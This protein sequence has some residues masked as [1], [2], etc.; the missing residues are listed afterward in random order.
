MNFSNILFAAVPVF[1]IVGVGYG[2]RVFSIV[3]DDSERSIMRLILNVLYPCFILSKV[4]GNESLEHVN[5]VVAAIAAG[6]GLTVL[7]LLI[8]KCIGHGIKLDPAD[9]VN[10]FCVATAIQNYGF[11]PIP[12]IEALFG[13]SANE[14]LGVLFVHNLGL[15]LAMWTIAII[16]LSGTMKGASRRLINGPTI[17]IIVGLFLNFTGLYTMIP[18]FAAKAIS[19]LGQCSIPMGLILAGATLAGVVQREKWS[20]DFKVIAGSISVRF[21]VMPIVFLLTASLLSFSPELRNVLIVEAAMPAAIF[22]IVM[23]KHFGGKPAIA[24]QIC[25]ATT[26]ASIVLTPVILLLALRWFGITLM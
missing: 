24:V 13:E 21:M 12:L 9:G 23:A 2:T 14:T 16:L 5:V 18:E 6:F 11:I 26:I 7:G 19:D 1:L 3:N 10:T 25:I 22:P 17:A 4:P 20:I 15:E 8:A